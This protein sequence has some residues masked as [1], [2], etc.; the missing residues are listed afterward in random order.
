MPVC[1]CGY[2]DDSFYRPP[3]TTVAKQIIC[4][5]CIAS[6]NNN[7]EPDEPGF[8]DISEGLAHDDSA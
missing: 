2:C 3:G 4:D 1:W 5:D 8:H 6:G 7:G